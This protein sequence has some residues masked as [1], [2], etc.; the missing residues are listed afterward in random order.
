[1]PQSAP[2]ALFFGIWGTRA[3]ESGTQKRGF[4][5]F[6][7]LELQFY[8]TASSFLLSRAIHPHVSPLFPTPIR[9]ARF[10]PMD[11]SQ[12]LSRAG[13]GKQILSGLEQAYI[14]G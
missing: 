2:Q 11:E 14:I 4:D 3:Q 8:N 7:A 12:G 1:V 5:C 13:M 6:G 9:N 10:I